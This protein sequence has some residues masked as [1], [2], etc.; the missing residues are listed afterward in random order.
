[1]Y[2]TKLSEILCNFNLVNTRVLDFDV[3]N[4]GVLAN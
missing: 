2:I 3:D 1:M 4:N